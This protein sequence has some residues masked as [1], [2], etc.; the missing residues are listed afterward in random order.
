MNPTANV[1]HAIKTQWNWTVPVGRG[2]RF[3][4]DM[5]PVL[6]A[7]IGNWDFNGVGRIQAVMVNMGNVRLVGMTAAELQA[8]YKHRRMPNAQGIETVFMMPEDIVDNTRRAFSVSAS[9]PTGYGSL[10]APEGRYFAPANGLNPD[11]T[12]CVQRKAGDCAPRTLLIRAPWFTMI[13]VGFGKR[14][15]F[16]GSSTVEVRLDL[17]NVFDNINFNNAANPGTSATQ[18]QVTSAYSDASN[19]YNPGGRLGQIMV[20]LT[21]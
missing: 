21:W 12:V 7:I 9:S 20:R 18:F 17:L 1:R 4:T 11:G 6:N 16:K 19:T 3:G 13:D 2:Q 5:H 15:P 10:G 8:E 14:F